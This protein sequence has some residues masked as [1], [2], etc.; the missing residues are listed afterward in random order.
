MDKVPVSDPW[1][2]YRTK[3]LNFQSGRVEGFSACEID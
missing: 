1:L 3:G 2:G